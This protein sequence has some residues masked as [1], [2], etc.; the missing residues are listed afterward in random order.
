MQAAVQPISFDPT[1]PIAHLINTES[2]WASSIIYSILFILALC[3]E[4]ERE[5]ERE[6]GSEEEME[7]EDASPSRLQRRLSLKKKTHSHFNNYHFW[8]HKVPSSSNTNSICYFT[9]T[10]HDVCLFVVVAEREVLQKGSRGQ[11]P[12]ALE[13]EVAIFS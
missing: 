10:I 1:R 13:I 3:G 5:R 12:L 11:N 6:R 8:K 9:I 2:E 4:R 7:D